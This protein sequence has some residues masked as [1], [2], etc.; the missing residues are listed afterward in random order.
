[1]V[2][3]L[4]TRET[5]IFRLSETRAFWPKQTETAVSPSTGSEGENN[6]GEDLKWAKQD[7]HL[8]NCPLPPLGDLDQQSPL[9]PGISVTAECWER[10]SGSQRNQFSQKEIVGLE[11]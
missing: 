7:A 2:L 6:V 10:V 11:E 9:A 4:G 3:N 5:G 1:M 8:E